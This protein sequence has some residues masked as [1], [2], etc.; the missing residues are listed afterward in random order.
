VGGG[1]SV[2]SV[3]KR[4]VDF[5][6]TVVTIHMRY[7]TVCKIIRKKIWRNGTAL[8]CNAEDRRFDPAR[9]YF[10]FCLRRCGERLFHF[11]QQAKSL[12]PNEEEARVTAPC[13]RKEELS[14]DQRGGPSPGREPPSM[15]TV[16]IQS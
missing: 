11:R 3:F 2:H 1:G 6:P 4:P 10:Y 8:E 9:D 7:C 12:S 13:W 14:R 15:P 5:P 16:S